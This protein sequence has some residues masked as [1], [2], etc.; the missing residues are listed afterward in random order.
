MFFFT[1][2]TWG[3]YLSGPLSSGDSD[4]FY[5]WK[6]INQ[7]RDHEKNQH[8]PTKL[9][10]LTAHDASGPMRHA[11]LWVDVEHCFTSYGLGLGN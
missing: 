6:V 5:E 10:S 7:H 4:V 9:E 1:A 11:F 3:L 2:K 8:I